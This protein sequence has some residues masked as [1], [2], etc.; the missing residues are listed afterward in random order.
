MIYVY[1]KMRTHAKHMFMASNSLMTASKGSGAR[2]PQRRVRLLAMMAELLFGTLRR[3]P[4]NSS[5][6]HLESLN[7]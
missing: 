2:T 1:K 5:E 4:L 7:Q 3:S 6:F